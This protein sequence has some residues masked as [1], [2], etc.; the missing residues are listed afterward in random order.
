MPIALLFPCLVIFLGCLSKERGA[1]GAAT[2]QRKN[3]LKS[4]ELS[5]APRSLSV[6]STEAK[7]IV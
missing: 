4:F 5:G 1:K 6:L 3:A 2:N 7:H